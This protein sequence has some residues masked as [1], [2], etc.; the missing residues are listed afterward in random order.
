MRRKT[1]CFLSASC[2][3]VRPALSDKATCDITVDV[4]AS[5]LPVGAPVA[6]DL[7]TLVPVEP[8]PAQGAQDDLGVLLGRAGGIGVID[9]QDKATMVRAGKG[10]VIDRN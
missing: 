10:P 8:Q 9:A 4:E 7:G 5:C 2:P 3:V 1:R 6:T